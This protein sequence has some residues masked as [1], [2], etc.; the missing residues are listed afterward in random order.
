[1]HNTKSSIVLAPHGHGAFISITP[2]YMSYNARR[3]G[4]V[5]DEARHDLSYYTGGGA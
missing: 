4:D 5:A 1:M 2:D 3:L